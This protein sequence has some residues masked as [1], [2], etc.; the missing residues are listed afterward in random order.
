[1]WSITLEFLKFKD[2]K[3]IFKITFVKVKTLCIFALG[4]G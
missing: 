3:N 1:L 2:L 4:F